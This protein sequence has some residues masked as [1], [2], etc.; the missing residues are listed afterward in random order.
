MAKDLGLIPSRAQKER[1]GGG[2]EGRT[3]NKIRVFKQGVVL[4]SCNLYTW[5]L[6]Q[7]DWKLE[8]SLGYIVSFPS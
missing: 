6:R 2:W 3:D 4:H 1:E 5:R 7:K 8:A